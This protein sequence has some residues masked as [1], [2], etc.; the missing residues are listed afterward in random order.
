MYKHLVRLEELTIEYCAWFDTHDFMVLSK[1]PNLRYLSLK[2]CA[3]IKDS[4]PYASLATRFGFKKL[5]VLD[6]RDTPISDSDVSCF[7]IVHSLKELRLECPEHLR[8][9]RGLNEY[10]EAERQ[11]VEQLHRLAMP[12]LLQ[13][14]ELDRV[15][16]D[17]AADPI[18]DEAPAEG[19]PL[20]PPIP[21]PRH[22]VFEIRIIHG[23]YPGYVRGNQDN[24]IRI[25]RDPQ[26][27]VA[28]N[29]AGAAG[30]I[31]NENNRQDRQNICFIV[32]EIKCRSMLL[33]KEF[34]KLALI[35]N[36]VRIQNHPNLISQ[37]RENQ[38]QDKMHLLNATY[39][40]AK[41][42]YGCLA[43]QTT[44][45]HLINMRKSDHNS[46]N[47]SLHSS[48]SSHHSKTMLNPNVFCRK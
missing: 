9:E 41:G 25:V 2:G 46:N 32:K 35:L 24:L 18:P 38:H 22:G 4:V 8:T 39:N 6:L 21:R 42:N 40:N 27:P 47:N 43:F 44:Y 36:N 14:E 1:L 11:R 3:N 48:N 29:P 12:D 37:K 20:P 34:S 33:S 31:A 13:N 16:D 30:P 19:V 7:N 23:E 10:N 17:V 15:G 45:Q 5:E 28:N 26:Q